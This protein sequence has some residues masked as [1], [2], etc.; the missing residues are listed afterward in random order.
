MPSLFN[1]WIF[2]VQQFYIKKKPRLVFSLSLNWFIENRMILKIAHF[3]KMSH[4]K[5]QLDELFNVETN[6]RKRTDLC[7]KVRYERTR[8]LLLTRRH[9]TQFTKAIM[10]YVIPMNGQCS[11]SEQST[12][13]LMKTPKRTIH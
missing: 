6:L 2:L 12:K 1:K 4:H 8:H 3:H 9:W 7:P 5:A 13:C 11:W 10:K